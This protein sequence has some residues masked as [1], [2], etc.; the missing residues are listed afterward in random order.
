MSWDWKQNSVTKVWKADVQRGQNDIHGVW[1]AQSSYCGKWNRATK[2][3]DFG[4]A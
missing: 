1:L 3:M 4:V 2:G